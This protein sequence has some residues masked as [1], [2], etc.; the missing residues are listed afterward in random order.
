MLLQP[1]PQP[2]PLHHTF[3]TLRDKR[4]I[5]HGRLRLRIYDWRRRDG[6]NECGASKGSNCKYERSRTKRG[7]ELAKVSAFNPTRLFRTANKAPVPL[8][9]HV[10]AKF[11]GRIS[12]RSARLAHQEYLPPENADELTVREL[13]DCTRLA[14][15]LEWFDFISAK[16][17]DVYPPTGE[18]LLTAFISILFGFITINQN[19]GCYSLV[20]LDDLFC[21]DLLDNVL[22]EPADAALYASLARSSSQ[23]TLA[24]AEASC[25]R[26]T[27]PTHLYQHMANAGKANA[28]YFIRGA[29]QH[30]RSRRPIQRV[31][32]S[33]CAT[34]AQ[35]T[36]APGTRVP[37][38]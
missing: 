30:T 17:R 5:Q 2:Y 23:G 10:N 12:R 16:Y 13:D 33:D 8:L 19:K 29:P 31:R 36:T 20:M 4:T 11:L 24:F 38:D 18:K 15:L 35:K 6:E 21:T 7:Y 22:K 9:P 25:P 32:C 28:I 37:G 26:P 27:S 34:G 1:F 14:C 3:F